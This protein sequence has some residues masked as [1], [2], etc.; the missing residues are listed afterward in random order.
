MNV[1]NTYEIHF[2]IADAISDTFLARRHNTVAPIFAEI[3]EFYRVKPKNLYLSSEGQQN[4][5]E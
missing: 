2:S 3:S 4:N 1:D 5:V